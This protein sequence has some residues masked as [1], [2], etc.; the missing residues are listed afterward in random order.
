M[1]F[2]KGVTE[3]SEVGEADVSFS[4]GAKPGRIWN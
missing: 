1:F 3:K 4:I 2:D